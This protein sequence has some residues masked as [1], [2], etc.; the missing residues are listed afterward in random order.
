MSNAA[1]SR[2]RAAG[3]GTQLKI[4]SSASSGSP[5]KYI[6]VISRVAKPGPNSEKWMWFGRQALWWLRHG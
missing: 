2:L 5:G 6:W 1:I 4:G 3:S